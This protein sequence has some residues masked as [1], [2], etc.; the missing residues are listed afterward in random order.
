MICVG[1]RGHHTR[2]TCFLY[3][4]NYIFVLMAAPTLLVAYSY[5]I[6]INKLENLRKMLCIHSVGNRSVCV[7]EC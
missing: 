2:F 1:G 4:N 6:L 3:L 7:C 5:V